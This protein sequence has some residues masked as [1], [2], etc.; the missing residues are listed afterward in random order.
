ML[1]DVTIVA[2]GYLGVVLCGY[3][4]SWILKRYK[5][6]IDVDGLKNSGAIIGILERILILT[7]VLVNQYIAISIII[8]AKSVRFTGLKDKKIED[9][10]LIGMLLSITMAVILGVVTKFLMELV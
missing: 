1:P 5:K 9:Y 3:P 10:Y 6:D 8:G 4:I 2:L 7:F